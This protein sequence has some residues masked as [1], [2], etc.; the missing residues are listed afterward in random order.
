[1]P[2]TYLIFFE[3]DKV[4]LTSAAQRI[5]ATAAKAAKPVRIEVIGHADRSGKGEYNHKISLRRANAVK[6][7]LIRRGVPE[8]EVAVYERGE[9]E[10]LVT[11]SDGIRESQNRRVEIILR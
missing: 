5:L 4:V 6:T 11:T 7:D 3:F 10:P 9:T 2:R 1:A 8:K